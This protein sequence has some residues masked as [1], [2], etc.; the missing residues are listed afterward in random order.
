P[1]LDLI[2]SEPQPDVLPNSIAVLPFEN[3]SPDPD[4]AYFAA[5]IHESTL[6]QLAKIS[7]LMVMSRTSVMQF[8]E[9]RPSIPEIARA[10]NVEA[11]LEGSVRYADGRVLIAAQLIDGSTDANVW[12]DE[13]DRELTDVFAVQ[14]DVAEKIAGA[15]KAELL[16]EEQARIE[17][18]PTESQVAYEH[19]LYALSLPYPIYAPQYTSDYVGSLE[20]AIE[21]DPNF[22][23]AY[24][25]L[26]E[27]YYNFGDRDAV[28]DT[29]LRAIEL[30]PLSGFA[31][32][33]LGLYYGN[34]YDRWSE[35]KEAYERAIELSPNN[36]TVLVR[37][38]RQLAEVSG[39]YADAIELGKR[40]A[41][42]DPT[43]DFVHW[44][45]GFIYL[46]AGHLEQASKHLEEAIEINPMLDSSHLDLAFAE[47]LKGDKAA[48][49]QRLDRAV[50][51]QNPSTTF[52][53][54]YIPYLYGLIGDLDT[55][56]NQL[57]RVE[58]LL[59][60]RGL[61]GTGRLAWG[62]L[63]VRDKERALAEWTTV[64]NGYLNG[65]RPFSP[66]R[67]SRFRDNWLNDPM[68]E[69]PEFLE[70]RR[71]LGFKG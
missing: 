34:Y 22:A 13:F 43:S 29:A 70:L 33:V 44:R 18:Q 28:L 61:L 60:A 14:K 21:A 54:D 41:A 40:A 27:A 32:A 3:L 8:Q 45:V 63:G 49:K 7:D 9:D 64:I 47:Y 17:R 51:V 37:S 1:A 38:A 53:V 11:I 6:N 52:R 56:A 66:S 50:A 58:E 26:A 15:L 67:V 20:K 4:N 2:E 46:R 55:A 62:V 25:L 23:D 30:D 65:G 16:P 5:G 36:A 42:I 24:A 57:K 19:Y 69:E 10:L 48:A 35:A 59:S 39:E 68:L 31:H 12:A 71:R